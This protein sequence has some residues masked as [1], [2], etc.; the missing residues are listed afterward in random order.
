MNDKCFC[1]LIWFMCWLWLYVKQK[2]ISIQ[3]MA[4][5]QAEMQ[6]VMQLNQQMKINDTIQMLSGTCWDLCVGT[7]GQKLDSR[8]EN[9]VKNC[10]QRFLDSSN[11]VVNRLEKEGQSIMAH[12]KSAVKSSFDW[13]VKTYIIWYIISNTYYCKIIY[14]MANSVVYLEC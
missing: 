3:E 10:V 11:Y 5:N 6:A 1:W 2:C 13:I 4:G 7:P 12:E 14:Y 9:C 8:T